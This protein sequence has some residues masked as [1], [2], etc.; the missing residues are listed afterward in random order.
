MNVNAYY[1]LG[2][3]LEMVDTLVIKIEAVYDKWDLS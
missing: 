3:I 2:T 1:L